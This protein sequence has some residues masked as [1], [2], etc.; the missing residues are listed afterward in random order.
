MSIKAP[1]PYLPYPWASNIPLVYALKAMS[2][3]KASEAQ[4]KMILREL[5]NLTGY[6][7]LSYRPDS[8]R[9]TAFAE[10]KRFVGAQVVKMVNLPSDV[11]EKAKEARTRK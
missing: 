1:E 3:G 7:D 6:Y 8:D 11:I 5:L 2:E 10:G 4:Q 9:D